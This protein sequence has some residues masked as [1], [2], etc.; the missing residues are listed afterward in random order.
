MEGREVREEVGEVFRVLGRGLEGGREG[1][2]RDG[3]EV[4][5]VGQAFPAAAGRGAGRGRGGEVVPGVVELVEVEVASEALLAGEAAVEPLV[6]AL[7]EGGKV[8][9]AVARDLGGGGVGVLAVVLLDLGEALVELAERPRRAAGDGLE[10]A[11]ALAVRGRERTREHRGPVH[12]PAHDVR[13]AVSGRELV[14]VGQVRRR[15]RVQQLGQRPVEHIDLLGR[16]PAVVL[17]KGRTHPKTAQGQQ[18]THPRLRL[19]VRRAVRFKMKSV[20]PL[21]A[22]SPSTSSLPAPPNC[23]SP[24]RA[25]HVGK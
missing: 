21:P 13:R 9:V 16:L 17:K 7:L 2:R 25:H 4:L 24:S 15:E 11:R 3:A 18:S 1:E 22:A 20:A 6:V 23:A 14:A 19:P 10:L 8:D 5:E 12:D